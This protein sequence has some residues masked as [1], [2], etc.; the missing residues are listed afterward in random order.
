MHVVSGETVEVR[1]GGTLLSCYVSAGGLDVISSGGIAS[2]VQ[3]AGGVEE[4]FG[5]A[6]A[7]SIGLASGGTQTIETGGIASGADVPSTGMQ[8]VGRGGS[9]VSS[10]VASGGVQF[11]LAGGIPP[12]PR[13]QGAEFAARGM[14]G[15]GGDQHLAP[16]DLLRQLRKQG[17]NPRSV[18]TGCHSAPAADQPELT[19]RSRVGFSHRILRTTLPATNSRGDGGCRVWRCRFRRPIRPRSWPPC[20]STAA[21]CCTGSPDPSGWPLC[22]PQR[23]LRQR[24]IAMAGAPP[25]RGW[26]NAVQTARWPAARRDP[27]RRHAG[28]G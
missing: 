17:V 11:V 10:L 4:V 2:G 1:A 27:P 25:T 22:G 28:V 18:N 6:I 24:A 20:S 8:S 15:G 26:I 5:V 12:A 13:S 7:T 23:P 16:F 19:G 3:H 14:D 9:A 21:C